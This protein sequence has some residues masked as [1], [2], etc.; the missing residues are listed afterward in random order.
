MV[1]WNDAAESHESVASDA[2][3]IPMS[4]G[5]PSHEPVGLT[6]DLLV[7]ALARQECGVTG[8][9]H[10]D[11]AGHLTHDELDVL[12][13]DRHALV[14]VHLLDLFTE[15]QLGLA[16]PLDLHELLGIERSFGEGLSG[17]DLV[18]AR[19][20]QAAENRAVAL[21]GAVVGDDR[22]LAALALVLRDAHYARTAGEASGT[23]WR[24]RLEQI[25][26][27]RETAGDVLTSHTTGVERTHRQLRAGLAASPSSMGNPVAS[28]RP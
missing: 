25:D 13:V 24:A 12:V 26:H 3:V 1:S 10:A 17:D 8:L 23:A 19:D 5:R 4:S 22:E 9:L 18:A 21:L 15:V 16:D 20:T 6:E 28:E 7:D 11:A 2:L 27:A 14:A